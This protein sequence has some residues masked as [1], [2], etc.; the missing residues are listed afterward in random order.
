MADT[1]RLGIIGLGQQG[2]LYA[3]LITE[4][5]VPHMSLGAIA[6]TDPAKRALAR[7]TYPGVPVYETTRTCS[8]GGDVDAVVTTIP[9]YLHPEMG[10]RRARRAASTP[11]SRSRPA[12]TPSRSA[13]L[14]A[15]AATQARAD[16][17]DHVQPAQPT[18]C[19]SRCKEIVD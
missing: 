10:D 9:H 16:V 7:T 11:W 13:E 6:D 3:S 4:G 18:R 17:R 2:G 5:K 1:V 19:T 14:I 12:S 15:F 8:P